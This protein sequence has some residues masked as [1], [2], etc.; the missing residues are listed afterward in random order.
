MIRT[1]QVTQVNFQLTRTK[2]LNQNPR[3]RPIERASRQNEARGDDIPELHQ[4]FQRWDHKKDA[5]RANNDALRR[6]RDALGIQS[7]PRL[8]Q[9]HNGQLAIKIRR[10][11]APS[12]HLLLRLQP[13]GGLR[14]NNHRIHERWF[15]TLSPRHC[16]DANR[17]S[18]QENN[19]VSVACHRRNPQ[20]RPLSRGH[21][22]QSDPTN[23]RRQ[24][25]TQHWV[26]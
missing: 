12:Q 6:K 18:Y 23:Q 21:Q 11:L 5:P 8:A 20:P 26:E 14:V 7:L 25:Q 4:V 19:L 24:N 13:P 17:K 3:A 16:D 15:L 10:N 22:G 2:I 1:S 9:I